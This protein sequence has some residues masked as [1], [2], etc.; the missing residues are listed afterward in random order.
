[1]Q[2]MGKAQ[3]SIECALHFILLSLAGG[4]FRGGYFSGF[5]GSIMLIIPHHPLTL[6]WALK[7]KGG[8]KPIMNYCIKP[9][10]PIFL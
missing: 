1:M 5:L 6:T 10:T 3:A 9:P 8:L 7:G 4:G 2:P